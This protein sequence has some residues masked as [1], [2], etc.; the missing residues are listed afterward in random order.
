MRLYLTFEIWTMGSHPLN[1]TL[2]FLLELAALA[3]MAVWGW[4]QGDGAV[5]F[6]LALS[7]PIAA[8]VVWGIFAVPH[9]PSRSGAAPIPTP[10]P[11][12]LVLELAIFG[13]ATWLLYDLGAI[14]LSWALGIIV[15]GHYLLSFD[16][17][18][19]LIRQ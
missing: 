8:A 11:L 1:L 15:G 2:R 9:D 6:L 19:W 17:I 14:G 10:G 5:R 7:M 3:A 4:R 13:L 16:R 18:L 12:R